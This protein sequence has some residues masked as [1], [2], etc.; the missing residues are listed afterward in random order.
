MIEKTKMR[1]D[2]RVECKGRMKMIQN[3]GRITRGVEGKKAE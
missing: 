2:E 1:R 3:H